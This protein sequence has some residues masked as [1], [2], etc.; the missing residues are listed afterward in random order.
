MVSHLGGGP[1][2]LNQGCATCTALKIKLILTIRAP[3]EPLKDKKYELI[4]NGMHPLFER[5]V[6]R[7]KATK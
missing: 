5:L 1:G 3:K 4:R 6:F 7:L 2:F